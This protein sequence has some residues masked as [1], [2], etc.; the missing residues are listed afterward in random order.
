MEMCIYAYT[1]AIGIVTAHREHGRKGCC[2]LKQ[3]AD[4]SK[5]T[6]NQYT[7]KLHLYDQTKIVKRLNANKISLLPLSH[8]HLV[9]A[10]FQN[11]CWVNL[12]CSKCVCV[13]HRH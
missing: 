9:A 7:P 10:T 12:T 2:C 6:K 8:S 4:N 5:S 11:V 1:G 3:R 13:N